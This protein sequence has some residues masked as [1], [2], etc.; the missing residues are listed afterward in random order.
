MKQRARWFIW[1]K[2]MTRSETLIRPTTDGLPDGPGDEIVHSWA[3]KVC[4]CGAGLAG[5]PP[6]SKTSNPARRVRGHTICQ[7]QKNE[8]SRAEIWYLCVVEL[9]GGEPGPVAMRCM[10]ER[11]RD[12]DEDKETEMLQA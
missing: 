5:G 11:C 9:G 7:R 1:D 8:D 6:Q 4:R 2:D 3:S 12:N 10:Q